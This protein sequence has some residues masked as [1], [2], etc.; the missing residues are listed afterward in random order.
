MRLTNLCMTLCYT[1]YNI[2]TQMEIYQ[3]KKGC[4]LW[5]SVIS[6]YDNENDS[7]F[8]IDETYCIRNATCEQVHY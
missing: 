7:D 4:G 8:D 3:L 2:N 1:Y 5:N 6:S